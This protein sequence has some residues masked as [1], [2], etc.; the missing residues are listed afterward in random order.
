[1]ANG[2]VQYRRAGAASGGGGASASAVLFWGCTSITAGIDTAR[3]LAPGF[4]S[5]TAPTLRQRTIRAPRAGTLKS[6]FLYHNN[7][8]GN[9][10]PIVYTVLVNNVATAITVTLA[11][12]GTNASDTAN[13]VAVAQGDEIDLRASKAAGIGNGNVMPTATLEFV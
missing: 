2:R 10:N 8:V 13:Q 3:F 1:M 4:D 11:S 7:P 5:G 12:T 6:L 9:G